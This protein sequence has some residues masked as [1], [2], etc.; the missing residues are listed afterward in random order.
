MLDCNARDD[1]RV[2]PKPQHSDAWQSPGS[3][4]QFA[5][6]VY[7]QHKPEGLDRK[8]HVTFRPAVFNRPVPA[9]LQNGKTEVDSSSLFLTADSEPIESRITDRDEREQLFAT[10]HRRSKAEVVWQA[11]MGK[12][13]WLP[14]FCRRTSSMLSPGNH[15]KSSLSSA[16]GQVRRRRSGNFLRSLAIGSLV[17][18]Q[19]TCASARMP[20][21]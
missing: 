7:G 15:S 4:P 18:M 20:T 3:L 6:D 16:H 12:K 11:F 13:S 14:R 21:R 2:T 8:Q 9:S 10:I 19:S 5:I 1:P 17:I